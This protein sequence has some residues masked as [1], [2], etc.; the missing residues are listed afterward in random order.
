MHARQRMRSDR[1]DPSN[2]DTNS[3][4][5]NSNQV[6]IIE[7]QNTKKHNQFPESGRN[8]MNYQRINHVIGRSTDRSERLMGGGERK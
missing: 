2:R 8:L 5:I 7:Q 1:L 4:Q 3:N 6:D